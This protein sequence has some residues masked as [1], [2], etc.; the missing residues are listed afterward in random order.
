MQQGSSRAIPIAIVIAGIFVAVAVY[1]VG[2]ERSRAPQQSETQTQQTMVR[3]VSSD[4]HVL[5]NPAAQVV[6]I[7]YS[8]TECPYCKE[9]HAT[10]RTLIETYGPSGNVSWV[11]RHFPITQLHPKAA[12]E[13]EAL[14]CAAAQGGTKGFWEYTNML[15]ERATSNNTLDIGGYNDPSKPPTHS[16]AGMLSRIATDVGLNVDVFEKCLSSGTYASRVAK[17]AA[18]AEAEGGTGTPM[19]IILVGGEQIF[20]PGAQSY[21]TLKGLIDTLLATSA[22]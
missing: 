5:G 14:E 18:E 15:Y 6:I 2:I 13:A 21:E 4:D 3:P 11:Y 1:L 7:G 17:D 8:D 9:Y 12:K 22:Q 19:S 10:L 16:G 20:V